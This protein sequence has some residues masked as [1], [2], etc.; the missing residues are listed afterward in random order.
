MGEGKP[1]GKH[2]TPARSSSCSPALHLAADPRSPLAERQH[3]RLLRHPRGRKPAFPGQTGNDI[4]A[5]LSRKL[6]NTTSCQGLLPTTPTYHTGWDKA[7]A[8]PPQRNRVHS[9]GDVPYLQGPHV[10][11][12][13]KHSGYTL[14]PGAASISQAKGSKCHILASRI[15]PWGHNRVQKALKMGSVFAELRRQ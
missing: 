8:Q 10:R 9:P 15:L 2:P 12:P 6:L 14:L 3:P 13:I 7:R 4:V 5:S 1:R 11:G